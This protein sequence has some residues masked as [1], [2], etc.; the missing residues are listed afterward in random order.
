MEN[1][2][3]IIGDQLFGE[4]GEVATR[5]AFEGIFLRAAKYGMLNDVRNPLVILRGSGKSYADCPV[6]IIRRH[7]ND[8]CACFVMCVD[9]D[10]ASQVTDKQALR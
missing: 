5:C 2:I 6:V 10:L 1:R 9:S 7:E 4:Q 8:S 3:L